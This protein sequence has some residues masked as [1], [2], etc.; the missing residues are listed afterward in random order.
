MLQSIVSDLSPEEVC[1]VTEC[2]HCLKQNLNSPDLQADG[3]YN[4]EETSYNET[5]FD[6]RNSLIVSL[7][8][9]LSEISSDILNDYK[10][11]SIQEIKILLQCFDESDQICN[12]LHE[13][14]AGMLDDCYTEKSYNI[15]ERIHSMNKERNQN[16]LDKKYQNQ[17]AFDLGWL[18]LKSSS[19][20]VPLDS[21]ILKTPFTSFP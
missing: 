14:A 16:K 18:K 12:F 19:K 20:Q 8:N 3:R 1:S 6:D 4:A 13:K 5:T 9:I 10:E 21:T 7:D 2:L 15:L 11:Y 17:I